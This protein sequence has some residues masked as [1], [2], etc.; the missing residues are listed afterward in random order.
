MEGPAAP[1]RPPDT[2]PRRA[3]LGAYCRA[4]RRLENALGWVDKGTFVLVEGVSGPLLRLVELRA[5]DRIPW[6]C[7][8]GAAHAVDLL[9][10]VGCEA[11]P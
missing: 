1:L 11:I 8:I 4:R 3:W 9:E 6:R 5:D 2:L 7:D 10:R